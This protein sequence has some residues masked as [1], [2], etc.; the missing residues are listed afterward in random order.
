[1]IRN[2]SLNLIKCIFL[3]L[4]ADQELVNKTKFN[5]VNGKFFK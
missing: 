1:M 2:G 4:S 3:N 5:Y